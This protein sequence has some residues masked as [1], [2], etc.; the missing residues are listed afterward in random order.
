MI[1]T[2]SVRVVEGPFAPVFIAI[3]CALAL[4][5][6]SYESVQLEELSPDAA[7]FEA[8]VYPLLLRDCAFFACHG[9]GERFFRIYGPGRLRISDTLEA[10]D[11]ATPA[12]V[13]H[14]Y[15]R[16]RSMLRGVHGIDDS[17][18]LRKPLDSS[19]GGAG[20]GHGG[21][22]VWGHNVYRS[23]DDVAYRTILKWAHAQSKVGANP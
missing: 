20:R 1:P 13:E 6:C 15:E 23:A 14:T 21:T 5:S 4:C 16:A 10:Y 8:E 17:V 18:L 19:E 11:P 7:L 3:L 22:D 9:N 12:E 2:V